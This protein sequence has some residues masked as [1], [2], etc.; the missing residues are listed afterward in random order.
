MTEFLVKEAKTK[1]CVDLSAAC[2]SIQYCQNIGCMEWETIS[3]YKYSDINDGTWHENPD[4]YFPFKFRKE[5]TKDELR[6]YC[7][8]IENGK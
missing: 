2:G 4:P 1:V 8:R 6:G 5:R 7:K 3:E